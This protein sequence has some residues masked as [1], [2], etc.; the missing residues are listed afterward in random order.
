MASVLLRENRFVLREALVLALGA[1]TAVLFL[2]HDL[3]YLRAGALSPSA[4]L[5]SYILATIVFYLGIRVVVVAVDLRPPRTHAGAVQCPECG[6]W[7]DDVS[8]A[9][10]ESHHR[11]RAKATEKEAVASLALRKAVEAARATS[12]PPETYEAHDLPGGRAVGLG[13]ST[14]LVSALADPDAL[15]RLRHS[16]RPPLEPRDEPRIKR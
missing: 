8:A 10:I 15:E 1:V 12:L 2:H 4:P 14:D 5:A 9:E 7:L 13:S 6:Q 16:P 11:M 3:F